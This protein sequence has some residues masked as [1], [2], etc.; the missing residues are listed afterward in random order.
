MTTEEPTSAITSADIL[1]CIKVLSKFQANNGYPSITSSEYDLVRPFI[2]SLYHMDQRIFR[3]KNKD[4]RRQIRQ[5]DQTAKNTCLLRSGRAQTIEQLQLKDLL[6][7]DGVVQIENHAI[8]S[9]S[10]QELVQ[11]SS[12]YICKLKYRTLHFFY[13]RLCPTCAAFNYQKRLQT[14]DLS[15]HIALVTGG[16]VKIGYRIVLKLLRSNCFVIGTSRFPMDFLNRLNKEQDFEQWKDRIH[17]YGVDF[18]YSQLVECFTEMLIEKYDRLDFLINNACQTIQRSKDYYQYLYKNERLINYSLLSND[19]QNILE[20]NLQFYQRFRP[21][22]NRI[23]DISN[24][25]ALSASNEIIEYASSTKFDV[26][27][28]PIDLR[29]TNSWLLRLGDLS[30]NEINEVLTI[31]TLAPFILNSKLKVLM[32]DRHPNPNEMKFIINVSAMEGSFSRLHKTDRHPHTNAAK[33]ALNMMTR[34]SAMDYKRSNIYMVSVDT[35]W[36]ND[37]DPPEKAMKKMIEKDFQTPLD[38]EDAAA[39]I[40]DPI[41]HTYQQI[42]EGKTDL[43][44]VYGCLLKDYQICNW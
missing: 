9:D 20:G 6:V 7:P 12:C 13:D 32:A 17:I 29:P 38:E 40:L 11:L 22:S 25:L 21:F 2:Q 43:Q 44:I 10:T 36:I 5:Q 16:R 41:I 39:R 28:Q 26:N 1:T 24:P 35:G 3:K 42:A 37:E 19:E 14:T 18:R 34:T 23:S 31:N 30:S 27:H 15:N 4:D 33:A 8:P